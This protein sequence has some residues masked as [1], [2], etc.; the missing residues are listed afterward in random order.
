VLSAI[1]DGV[2][3]EDAMALVDRRPETYRDWRKNDAEFAAAVDE[4]RAV[5]RSARSRSAGG[6]VEVPDFPEFCAEYLGKPLPELHLRVWDVMNGR[7]P[8][9]MHPAIRFQVGRDNRLLLNFAP[10]HAK[11][12]VWSVHYSLWRMIKDPNVRIAVVSKTQALA[13]KIVHEI[14]QILSLPQYAKLHAAFMP[15]G[16]WKGDSWTRTEIYLSGVDV[17]QKDPSL[18]AL[19]LGGQIYGSRLDVILL[20]DLVDMKNTHTYKD[21]A[22]WVGTEVDSRVDDDGLLAVLGTRLAPDDLYSELRDLVDY[23]GETPV[24]TWFAQPAVLEMPEKDPTTWVTVWPEMWPGISLARKKAV[25]PSRVALA[26]DL[27]ADGRLDRPGVPVRRRHR[28]DR[29]PPR[30]RPQEGLY[31]VLGVDPAADGFT[32]MIVMGVDL[33]TGRRYVLEGWNKAKCPP[34]LLVGKIKELITRHNVREAVDRAQRLPGVPDPAARPA[35][36]L[37]RQLLPADR[38][39]HRPAEVG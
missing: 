15:E 22:D 35:R 13:K 20:D 29:P 24:W 5:A 37:L 26:A 38:A 31:C 14:K 23:D 27:P 8:R 2:K 16:G 21:L 4:M 11:T 10:Y 36:L 17:A 39:L 32:A 30:G 19:G 9:A 25:L 18:Q 34:E 3:V 33:A 7:E 12:S 1:R 28:R 6:R